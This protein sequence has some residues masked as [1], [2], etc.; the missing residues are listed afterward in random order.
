MS[1]RDR[2]LTTDGDAS[3]GTWTLTGSNVHTSSLSLQGLEGVGNRLRVQFLLTHTGQGTC[4]VALTLH[5][6]TYN[7]HF[8]EQLTVFFECHVQLTLTS[9]G[10]RLIAI[11]YIADDEACF[12]GNILEREVTVEIGNRS[13]RCSFYHDAGTDDCLTCRINNSSRHLFLSPCT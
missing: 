6:V 7:H 1:G 4:H 2:T 3:Y 11:A 5:T 10:N 9:N 13:C 8:V 12:L